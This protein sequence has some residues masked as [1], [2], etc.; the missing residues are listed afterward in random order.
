[1]DEQPKNEED[2]EA[3]NTWMMSGGHK[4]DMKGGGEGGGAQLHVQVRPQ[5][6]W[7]WVSSSSALKLGKTPGVY[8]IAGSAHDWYEVFE[9]R[10]FP[11][12]PPTS[13]WRHSRDK[14]SRPSCFSRLFHFRVIYWTQTEEHERRKPGNEARVI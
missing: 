6:T 12:S 8:K 2:P 10:P 5:W 13:T 11:L 9:C 4:A 14:C 1:M 7:E 3:I